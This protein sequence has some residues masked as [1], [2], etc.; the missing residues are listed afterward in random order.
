M[1]KKPSSDSLLSFA[2]HR[3]VNIW[4]KITGS[5]RCLTGFIYWTNDI[6]GKRL[7]VTAEVTDMKK[8][9]YTLKKYSMHVH[10]SSVSVCTQYAESST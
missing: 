9:C 5:Q 2:M 3:N 1:R 7:M 4:A 10:I 6:T 8:C